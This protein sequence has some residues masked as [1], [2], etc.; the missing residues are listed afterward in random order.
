MP[1]GLTG[2][3]GPPDGLSLCRSLKLTGSAVILILGPAVSTNPEAPSAGK[4]IFWS[5][6]DVRP[7]L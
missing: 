5:F 6:W 7:E 3:S 1:P 2:P 4:S